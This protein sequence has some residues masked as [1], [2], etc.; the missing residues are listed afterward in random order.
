MN[1]ESQPHYTP[2]RTLQ[3]ET[4][5][6]SYEDFANQPEYV[7]INQEQIKTLTQALPNAFLHVDIATGTGLVPKLI[8][9]ES[10]KTGRKGTIWGI[11]PNNTSLKIA[12]ETTPKSNNVA[13]SYVHGFGQ[14][15]LQLLD[16]E[17]P[18]EGINSTS[19]HDALHEVGG[20]EDKLIILQSMAN[21][22]KPGGLFS[23]NSAFT[24]F[25]M[26]PTPMDWGRWKLNAFRIL[27]GK[28][29]RQAN[30]IEIYTPEQYKQMIHSVGLVVVHQEKNVVT[31][32][33][34]ALEAISRYP[35]FVDGVFGDM[36]DQENFSLKQKSDA[37]IKALNGTQSMRRGWYGIIAQKPIT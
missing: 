30:P 19:I 33:Q 10:E 8:I 5:S 23:F 15:A 12:R 22:L 18:Q 7:A 17:I 2:T 31:L 25:G 13:V 16:G 36:V 21:M 14:H 26:E 34:K 4:K 24:T 1:C 20:F 3:T 32:T 6:F 29:D 27:G 9:Q 37:L 11:D 35:K 28:K